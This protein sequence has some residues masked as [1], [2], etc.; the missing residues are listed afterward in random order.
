MT[1]LSPG[2]PVLL[3]FEYTTN[4]RQAITVSAKIVTGDLLQRTIPLVSTTFSIAT[5]STA[6][7]ISLC[8]LH[9]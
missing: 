3:E 6:A 2:K 8:Q 5:F 1:L 9:S 4:K 7:A